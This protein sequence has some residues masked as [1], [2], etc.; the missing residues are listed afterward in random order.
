[1]HVCTLGVRILSMP[2][3][4]DSLVMPCGIVSITKLMASCMV[5]LPVMGFLWI[6]AITNYVMHV[7]AK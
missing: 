6:Y 4:Q 5:C 1:M 7:D 3:K 2:P